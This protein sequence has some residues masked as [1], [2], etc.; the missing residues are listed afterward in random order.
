MVIFRTLGQ[1]PRIHD[2]FNLH[3]KIKKTA[4]VYRKSPFSNV[5]NDQEELAQHDQQ[6][7]IIWEN[8][9]NNLFADERPAVENVDD[10]EHSGPPITKR[11]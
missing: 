4:E 1:L 8:Y 11:K 6:R 7:K 3:R 9:I 2:D 10:K 5:E